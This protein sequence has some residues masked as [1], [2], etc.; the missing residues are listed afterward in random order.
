MYE[1]KKQEPGKS[2]EID[3]GPGNSSS[4]FLAAV[5]QDEHA[6]TKQQ[7]KQAPHGA[8]KK[9]IG[10]DPCIKIQSFGAP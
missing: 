8:F 4:P 9:K 3:I 7:R 5:Q 10:G 6:N 2:S 1:T